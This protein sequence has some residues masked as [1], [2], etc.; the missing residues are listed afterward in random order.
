MPQRGFTYQLQSSLHVGT[1]KPYGRFMECADYLPGS[2]IRG[3][4]A[5]AILKHC[6]GREPTDENPACPRAE[7]SCPA[8]GGERGCLFGPMFVGQSPLLFGHAYPVPDYPGA[9]TWVHPAP[10][11]LRQCSHHPGTPEEHGVK[12]E[13][14]HRLPEAALQDTPH[15]CWD[16]LLSDYALALAEE[17]G[18]TPPPSTAAIWHGAACNHHGCEN[19]AQSASGYVAR[20]RSGGAAFL[21]TETPPMEF[22]TH[23]ALSR[24]RRSAQ[25]G[26]LFCR[27]SL[28][29]GTR[30]AGH[31]TWDD[32]FDHLAD[33]VTRILVRASDHDLAFGRGGAGGMGSIRVIV[34]AALETLRVPL[35]KRLSE[36]DALA[37]SWLSPVESAGTYFT[38]DARSALIPCAPPSEGWPWGL[39]LSDVPGLRVL[40]SL[41]RPVAVSGWSS[42]PTEAC[43]REAV[44]AVASG[45]VCLCWAPSQVD[46]LVGM[47]APIESRGVGERREMGC[48]EIEL[49]SPLHLLV[50]HRPKGGA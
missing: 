38:V 16:V 48:G 39:L 19:K 18:Q 49:S 32:G 22:R 42:M 37:R 21:A 2:T 4:V 36:F 5:E 15:G 8:W 31:L 29:R 11:T 30:L 44:Q 13:Y 1:R 35:A 46:E 40:H 6:P 20:V 33:V 17:G 9:S 3:A 47:L 10:L 14:L 28:R 50:P 23:V 26:L 27:Q 24:S 43:A 34:D 12:L 7:T 41:H 45:S 25:Q